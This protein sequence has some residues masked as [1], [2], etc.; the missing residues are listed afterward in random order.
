MATRP[1]LRLTF[2]CSHPHLRLVAQRSIEVGPEVLDGLDAHAQPQQ[3]GRQ[4]LLSRNAGPPFDGGLNGP[5]A[6]G[7]L[8]ELQAGADGV[9]GSAIA[10]HVE[11]DDRTEALELTSRGPVSG[12]AR[13]TGVARQ[14]DIWMVR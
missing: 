14:R 9:G 11:R 1:A 13:Q 5:Q 12:V 2:S 8:N 6:R 4:V 7:V 10:A 3:R